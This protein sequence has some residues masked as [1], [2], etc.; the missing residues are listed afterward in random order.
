MHNNKRTYLYLLALVMLMVMGAGEARAQLDAQLTQYWNVPSY[1]NPAATGN[2]DYIHIN[3][4]SRLQWVGIKHAP[5]SFIAL[6]DMPFK[7]IGR[8]WGTG[9]SIQQENEGLYRSLQAGAQLSWKKKM[10][11]GTLS[12]GVQAGIINETFKGSEII[13]PEG[14]E[15]HSSADDAIPHSDITGTTFDLSGGVMFTHKKFW[16]GL[17]TTHVL[18]PTV[19]LKMENDEE[20]RYEFNVQRQY[21]FMA[22]SNIPVKNTLFELQPS[23]MVKTDLDFFQAEATARVR[24]NKFLSGGVAYRHNDAVSLLLG[25]DYKNFFISYSYD[26]PINDIRKASSGS[27]EL[28]VGY[29]LKLNMGERN[30]NKHK[31][32]RIM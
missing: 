15:A 13:L 30:K 9:V 11:G 23:L 26:Y 31:S 16:V 25:A 3:A 5:M 28:F 22:G 12:V 4:G 14:D 17:S 18:A 1:Y 7:F 10:L 32:I 29:N 6:A 24:Y 27:H 2:I 19:S 21:Y 20:K 8:R